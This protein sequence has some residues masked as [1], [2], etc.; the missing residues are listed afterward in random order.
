VVRMW[1]AKRQL[2][3]LQRE[4]E[5]KRAAE[6]KLAEAKRVAEAKLAEE[7]R[8][9]EAKLAEEKRAAEAKLVEEKKAAEAKLAAEAEK[10]RAAEAKLAAEVILEE[11]A[12]SRREVE[13]TG[14]SD[15]EQESIKE[16]DETATTKVLNTPFEV[17]ETPSTEVYALYFLF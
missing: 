16:I 8:A 7:K 13:G 1:L 11:E 9:A 5:E 17:F 6:A 3:A 14:V 2:Y 15:E 12:R 4:V 10:K